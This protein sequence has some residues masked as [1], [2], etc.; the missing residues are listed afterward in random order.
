M[1]LDVE[2]SELQA[3]ARAQAL[4]DSAMEA[5]ACALMKQYG[6]FLPKPAKEFFREL[7]EF[8]NWQQLKKAI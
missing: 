3:A 6:F 1:Q 8:L 5:K 4:K 2:I 7:A